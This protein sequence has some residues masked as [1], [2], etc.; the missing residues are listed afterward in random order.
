MA[1]LAMLLDN[2]R[3]VL[4][5]G[6]SNF[7]ARLLRARDQ[8]TGYFRRGRRDRL[9]RQQFVQGCLEVTLC[10]FFSVI[11]DAVLIVD[12]AV[13]TDD[14][15]RIQKERLRRP[16]GPEG[17]GHVLVKVLQDRE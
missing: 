8:A 14:M 11:A 16:R 15:F 10:W 5:V 17:I 2:L 4:G 7:D 6:N 9:A 12:S 1:L 3:N 13:I